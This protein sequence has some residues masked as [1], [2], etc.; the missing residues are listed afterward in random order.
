M[1]VDVDLKLKAPGID[2]AVAAKLE[3]LGPEARRALDEF[4]SSIEDLA[5][6]HEDPNLRQILHR[7]F[8][9]SVNEFFTAENSSMQLPVNLMKYIRPATDEAAIALPAPDRE[10][11]ADLDE[12]F[13]SRRSQR[14]FAPQPMSLQTLGT[15]LGTALG[16]VDTEDGYGVRDLPLFPYPSMGGLSAFEVGIVVQKVEGVAPGYYVYDQ[17]GHQLV[18]KIVG[19]LRLGLQEVTFE[20]EWLL[21]APIVLAIAGRAEK[22]E[23]KYHTRGYRIGHIDMGAAVQSLY[24][25]AWA[26]QVGACAVAGFFDEAINSLLGYDG[27]DTYV[28][29]LMGMGEVATPLLARQR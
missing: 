8:V 16:K 26:S 23:W 7:V 28:S 29:L 3:D 25:S 2:P 18:P 9:R 5:A 1:S 14:S 24:L 20:S 19:D 4:A 6:N 27:A 21:Y 15:V 11:D 10:R 22:S 12:I 13:T 17:V